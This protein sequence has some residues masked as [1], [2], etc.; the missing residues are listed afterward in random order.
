M[1][2]LDQKT[3]GDAPA[4]YPKLSAWISATSGLAV[5]NDTVYEALLKSQIH[6]EVTNL[7]SISGVGVDA[8]RFRR[9]SQQAG[10]RTSYLRGTGAQCRFRIATQENYAVVQDLEVDAS[11]VPDSAV[12]VF[13]GTGQTIRRNLLVGGS[14]NRC[15]IVRSTAAGVKVLNNACYGSSEG[16]RFA[17]TVSGCK[18][19][20][21]T[22]GN[23]TTGIK[24]DAS[25]MVAE[26]KQNLVGN[27]ATNYSGRTL[28]GVTDRNVSSDATGDPGYT[29]K[30]LASEIT[31][32]T[33]GAEN[34][35]L[36]AGAFARGK[37]LA[38]ADVTT[39]Y[40]GDLRSPTPDLGAD[41]FAAFINVTTDLDFEAPLA[42]TLDFRADLEEGLAFAAALTPTL[43]LD[44]SLE[45]PEP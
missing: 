43:D 4:D 26:L 40:Q 11:A 39:D 18:V 27:G 9:I 12:D 21:N 34:A 6:T 2:G 5:A 24:I 29:G 20:H 19:L 22:V 10:A 33:V 31:S 17:N 25:G 36:Q 15:V 38:L 23:A 45:E 1:P 41:E 8:T 30:P 44:S 3:I 37:G 13:G 42:P 32:A 16:I 28:A 7:V 14:A 35:A